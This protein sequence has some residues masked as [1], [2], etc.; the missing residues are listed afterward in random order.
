MTCRRNS[1]E[2]CCLLEENSGCPL[3]TSALNMRGEIPFCWC[4]NKKG[5]R[6]H[7]L[8]AHDDGG[9]QTSHY[10]DELLVNVWWSNVRTWCRSTRKLHFY[11][12]Q[13]ATYHSFKLTTALQ[14][15]AP[16]HLSS[17][18]QT[19]LRHHIYRKCRITALPYQLLP[20]VGLKSS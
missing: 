8:A 14:H 11:P 19:W 2:S 9:E 7:R 15:L 18:I 17:C 1:W 20:M 4:W 16:T 5:W 10:S 13:V 12:M 6:S 3:L